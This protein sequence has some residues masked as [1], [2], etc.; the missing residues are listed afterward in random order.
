[1]RTITLV[2]GFV[3]KLNPVRGLEHEGY[4][5]QGTDPGFSAGEGTR[6]RWEGGRS[7]TYDFA[8][9]SQKLLEIENISGCQG[10]C[11]RGAI[12]SYLTQFEFSKR[13]TLK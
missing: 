12:R 7:P 1:M 9:L 4:V 11:T 6:P 5:M 3:K 13:K 8:K 2:L 10:M